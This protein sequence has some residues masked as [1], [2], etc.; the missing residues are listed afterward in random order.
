MVETA[1]E[2]VLVETVKNEEQNFEA[3]LCA[4][5]VV[6]RLFTVEHSAAPVGRAARS[7]TGDAMHM[8]MQRAR[9]WRPMDPAAAII[10][11]SMSTQPPVDSPETCAMVAKSTDSAVAV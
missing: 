4:F 5:N 8:P 6:T 2:T 7:S 9:Y 10:A 1:L 11:H 3:V